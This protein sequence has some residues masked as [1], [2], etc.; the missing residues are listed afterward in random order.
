MEK[1]CPKLAVGRDKT[2]MA[3][4]CLTAEERLG[5]KQSCGQG[6]AKGVCLLPVSSTRSH[7]LLQVPITC[8][9]ARGEGRRLTILILR[10]QACEPSIILSGLHIMRW[11]ADVPINLPLQV[12]KPECREVVIFSGSLHETKV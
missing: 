7:S 6:R 5:D 1:S 10:C 2:G 11:W 4:P 3:E 12:K 8:F 9:Q